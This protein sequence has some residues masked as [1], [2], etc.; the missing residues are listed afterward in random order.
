MAETAVS[1]I[2][3]ALENQRIGGLQIRVAALCTLI[4][5][6]DGYDINAVAWAVPSLI[7]AW[8][9]PPP[10]FTTAFLWSSIGIL[11]GALSAGPIGDRFGRKP[12]LLVSLTMFGIASLLSAFAGSLL[13]LTV[14][15]FFTGLGIGGAFPGAASLDRR[16]RAA[17]AARDDDHGELYRR[18]VGRLSRRPDRGLAAAA[19]RLAG[20]LHAGRRS[21]RW[22]WWSALALWLPKSPRFLAR[23]ANL[24]PREAALLQRLDIVPAGRAASVDIAQGNPIGMLFGKGYAL[25][26]MLLWVIYFCSLMNLFLFG[27]WMPRS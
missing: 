2:E 14:L 1:A 26:T 19:F 27:Y 13:M 18:A 20:H 24:S 22:S 25:Q 7:H 16:L 17:S 11:V 6:C 12:L 5:I 3:T 10:A 8:H 15:R 4:Q 21:S 23:K 9:L